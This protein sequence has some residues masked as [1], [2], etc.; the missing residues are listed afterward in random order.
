MINY[1]SRRA[2]KLPQEYYRL[3]TELL[4][5][6]THQL[7]SRSSIRVR[8]PPEVCVMREC[9]APIC[10][11]NIHAGIIFRSFSLPVI[12]NSLLIDFGM[13]VR[14]LP[15]FQDKK[16]AIN[17]ESRIMPRIPVGQINDIRAQINI[18][19]CRRFVESNKKDAL[20]RKVTSKET[21]CPKRKEAYL[22]VAILVDVVWVVLD[23]KCVDMKTFY[24]TVQISRA[25]IR[26]IALR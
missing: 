8:I 15:P 23:N 22:F 7:N 21:L 17:D 1:A 4:I 10:A 25:C 6:A 5:D 13:R 18:Y 16:V 24:D 20:D 12:V 9:T 11:I 3:F 14:F 2:I 26:V 19:S